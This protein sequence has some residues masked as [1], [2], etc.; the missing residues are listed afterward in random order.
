[1]NL[2]KP[3]DSPFLAPDEPLRKRAPVRDENGRPVIDFMMLFPGLREKPRIMVQ[4]AV[5]EV[6]IILSRY[7]D[8]VVFAEFN[9]KLNLLWVS[10]R[11]IQGKRLEIAGAIQEKV[12]EARLVAH[13]SEA[14]PGGR[15]R[16]AA[17]YGQ[18]ICGCH[19]L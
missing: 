16:T 18:R 11:A 9:M 17:L 3:V 19:C 4:Q 1:M 2:P 10:L 13:I 15:L 6:Q 8:V 5:R 7:S 12:P 14:D